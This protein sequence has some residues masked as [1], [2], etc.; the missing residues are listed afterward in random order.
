MIGLA[1]KSLYDKIT[2]PVATLGYADEDY[3]DVHQEYNKIDDWRNDY[4]FQIEQRR[5]EEG[6]TGDAT[7]GAGGG[8]ASSNAPGSFLQSPEQKYIWNLIKPVMSRISQ[9]VTDPESAPLWNTGNIP[10]ASY[11][12]RNVDPS[13]L[14]PNWSGLD[15]TL[16]ESMMA[17][18]REVGEQLFEDMASRGQAGGIRGGMTGAFG[19][20]YAKRIGA[21]A[22]T[23][24]P[25]QAQQMMMPAKQAAFGL[26]SQNAMSN[27]GGAMEAW[28]SGIQEQQYPYNIMPGMTSGTYPTPIIQAPYMPAPSSSFSPFGI[29]S[30]VM[31]LGQ[32]MGGK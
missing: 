15:P 1:I 11:Y 30:G 17:P 3:Y 2:D 27:Y 21:E 14:M 18:Y 24:I 23:T 20:A 26:Q 29:M 9:R 31:G 12:S 6:R 22:A 5:R 28:R 13:I 19:D 8:S 10:D 32:M 16:K 25:L 7:S 4:H